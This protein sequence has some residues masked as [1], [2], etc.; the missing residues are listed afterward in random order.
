MIVSMRF[1]IG[2]ADVVMSRSAVRIGCESPNISCESRTYRAKA[3]GFRLK[4]RAFRRM[5]AL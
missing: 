3:V 2:I 4:V 1:L 5:Q